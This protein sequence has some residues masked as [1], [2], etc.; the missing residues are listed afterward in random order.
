MKQN[1]RIANECWFGK[2]RT[3]RVVKACEP[4]ASIQI[5][6]LSSNSTSFFPTPSRQRRKNDGSVTPGYI[7]GLKDLNIEN[8]SAD[9]LVSMNIHGV[10]VSWVKSLEERGYTHLTADRLVD[11]RIHG[12]DD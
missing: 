4:E 11:M 7:K 5:E 2:H 10:T 3:L 8:L 1:T 6:N 9:D 12:N